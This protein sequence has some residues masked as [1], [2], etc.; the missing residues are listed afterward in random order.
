MGG[1]VHLDV[2]SSF[3]AHYGASW[4]EDLVA[5]AAADDADAIA[6]VD[7]DGLYGAIKHVTACRVHDVSPIL[8]VNLQVI[9]ELP[10]GG[11]ADRGRVVLLA[12]GSAAGYAALCRAVSA[13]H[14]RDTGAGPRLGLARLVEL[15]CP[16]GVRTVASGEADPALFVLLGPESDVGTAAATRRYAQARGLLH[17]WRSALGAAPLRIEVVS[18]L[19]PPG[20]ALS[21]AHAARMLA[22]AED[23]A[24]DPVL[25]NMVRFAQEDDATTA[26]VLD[27]VRVLSS[28]HVTE[29]LQPN[30]QGWLKPART[31]ERLAGEICASSSA[32][33]IDA[34]DL[35]EHTRALAQR[36]LLDPVAHMSFRVPKVPEA[37]VIGL[38]RQGRCTDPRR[39]LRQRCEAG[40]TARFPRLSSSAA[41]QVRGRLEHELTIIEDLGF[42]S[43]FLTVAEVVEMVEQMEV[44]VSARGSG[45]S[46]LVNHLLRISAVDPI[47]HDLIFERFLSR[48]RSTL[49]DID[50]DVESARRH[51][52]YHRIFERFGGE[53]TTLMSMQNSYRIRGA[54]R[55]A[56]LALGLPEEEIA[57]IAETMWRFPASRFREALAEKPELRTLAARLDSERSQGRQQLD[58]LVDLTERLDRLPRHISTH[59]CGVILGDEQL[60]DLTPVQPSGVDGLPMSQ[61]DKHDMDP[62][63]FLKL[64]VL[65]VR[66]QSTIAYALQE[67]RRT[68]G[69]RIELE[70]VDRDDEATYRLIQST[71]TLGC[72]QIES[73]GQRE[74]V[75]KLVPRRFSDLVVDIS[76]FR[77]GPMGSGMVTPYLERRHGFE[78]VASPHPDL[79]DVLAET[80]GVTIYHEQVLRI[81]DTMTR[82]GLAKA[83][84]LRR[85]LGGETHDTVK[86]FFRTRAAARGYADGVIEEVWEI[87]DSFG[88]F[89]FCKAHGAAFAVPTFESAWL[90]THHPAAFLA[91]L[92]EHDPGMYPL[93]LLVAEARRLGVPL[94]GMDVNR[95]TRHYVLEELDEPAAAGIRM[96]LTSLKGISE[97]EIDRIVEAQPFDS[98]ADLRDRARPKRPTLR[99]LAQVGALDSLMPGGLGRR[100]D[101]IAAVADRTRARVS[102]PRRREVAGQLPL[103]LPDVEVSSL[104]ETHPSPTREEL[105]SDELRLTSIDVTGHVMENHW[106]ALDRFEVTRAEDLLELRSGATVRVAG[107][108]VATQTPPMASGKRVVFISLDDGT[109]CADVAFFEEAQSNA[110]EILFTAQLMLVEGTIRRTGPR[111]VSIQAADAWDLRR[112]DH[113][114]RLRLSPPPARRRA[115]PVRTGSRSWDSSSVKRRE[116]ITNR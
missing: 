94:L 1:F 87:L 38:G 90:K 50:I 6:C 104:P 10:D 77:P 86:T 22:I 43:Y 100:G 3:S 4:P 111:A 60:L 72:F 39:E 78:Q 79:A 115:Q 97:A 26:D 25:T 16:A 33:H 48:R 73:P 37:R 29:T 108:R 88:S 15:A 99:A 7:R 13:A 21:T 98:L 70:A 63:G 56:G 28:L 113:L 45:A 52:V 44:R 55:D 30:G 75:G 14:L 69:E 106:A 95:S 116:R 18:H 24:V 89:G 11:L 59:P 8:G 71:H 27:A 20:E 92:F 2:A 67:V 76:L 17:G 40:L 51:E 12:H 41:A 93:R 57:Q 62:M 34:V 101:L 80:H 61:F 46:S 23:C 105:I 54:V 5:A 103:P 110:G 107:I 36:C 74:L 19:A 83:D 49:P 91:G 81:F 53:R 114:E 35:L 109:G 32:A 112:E 102:S 9:E 66:M 96:A 42:S 58:L 85:A 65:G 68:T 31:M 64:D 47:E 84:E 82:C